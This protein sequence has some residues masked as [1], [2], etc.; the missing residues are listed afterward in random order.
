MPGFQLRYNM[1]FILG[2]KIGMSQVFDDTGRVIPITLIEAGP[3]KVT[4]VKIKE[5]DGYSAVQLGFDEI[6]KPKKI[7]KVS[8][9]KPY[10][11]L[12][13][14]SGGE[15]SLRDGSSHSTSSSLKTHQKLLVEARSRNGLNDLRVSDPMGPARYKS[16][17]AIT[18]EVFKEGDN[19]KVS[20]VSK[21]KGFQGGV[22][23]WGFSG[24]NATHGVK[25]EHRTLGS[26]G[27]TGPQ[28]VLKGK[29]MPGRLGFERVTVKNLKV[30]KV[31][32]E[33]NLLAV[34]GAVPGAKGTLL[35]IRSG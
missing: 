8:S 14:F 13:E 4:Q 35:E 9:G 3:C 30:V 17:D 23:R 10:R 15:Y 31:D 20:G 19:V 27:A 28:R 2:K 1:K 32:A 34:K 12:R 7:K 24:R 18:V 16:G 6:F 29:K 22:K 11:F 21:G 33:N 5:K 26:V 25:H